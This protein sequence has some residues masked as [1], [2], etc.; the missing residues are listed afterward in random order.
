MVVVKVVLAQTVADASKVMKLD[1]G[2]VF[3]F[4][5]KVAV[6][7]QA[8]GKAAQRVSQRTF[9]CVGNRQLGGLVYVEREPFHVTYY[10][11][12]GGGT[13]VSVDLDRTDTLEWH[14]KGRNVADYGH[15]YLIFK[16]TA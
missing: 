12:E 3:E 4:L 16:C 14:I 11:G 9:R 6:P 10:T 13:G 15:P 7:T 1:A 5:H 2:F 8:P